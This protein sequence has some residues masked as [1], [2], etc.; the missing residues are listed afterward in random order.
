MSLKA[1][2]I[3]RAAARRG[4]GGQPTR[5]RATVLDRLRGAQ[6]HQWI[7]ELEPWGILLALVGFV[8]AFYQFYDERTARREDRAAYRAELERQNEIF[9]AEEEDRRRNRINV[10][11]ANL[12]GGYG[13]LDAI[14]T[15]VRNGVDLRS[16]QAPRA[17]LPRANLEIC[18]EEQCDL[19]W[20][21]LAGADLFRA[22]M[23]RAILQRAN[24]EDV[25]LSRADISYSFLTGVQMNDA[26]LSGSML[27]RAKLDSAMLQRSDLSSSNLQYADMSGARLQEADLSS[28]DLQDSLLMSANLAGA[29]LRGADMDRANLT[30]AVLVGSDLR[31][32]SFTG[33]FWTSSF[34]FNGPEV[35]F[36]SGRPQLRGSL[37]H[38]AD[39]SGMQGLR[40]AMLSG[41]IGNSETRLPSGL[42]IASCWQEGAEE[43]FIRLLARARYSE[44]EDDYRENGWICPEGE[45][46]E[47]FTGPLVIPAE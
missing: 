8:F 12:A 22:Q 1:R 2:R 33:A 17:F 47:Y 35:L 10:A 6:V 24:L 44:S 34:E 11:L 18:G 41:V 30:D 23:S 26:D 36:K 46:P 45:D 9:A 15:L 21:N 42:R 32:A 27:L 43:I 29:N 7:A 28:T 25:N 38:D 40:Q 19:S 31:Y 13:R 5:P 14:D 39:L 37:L 20:A 4:N 16:L 3:R